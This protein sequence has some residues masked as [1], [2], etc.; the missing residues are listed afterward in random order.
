VPEAEAADLG[1][2]KEHLRRA[3]GAIDSFQLR[4]DQEPNGVRYADEGGGLFHQR[5]DG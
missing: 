1:K 5:P 2:D 3:H 4:V